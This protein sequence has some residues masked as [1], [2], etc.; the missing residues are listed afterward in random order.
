[1]PCLR[2]WRQTSWRRTIR[3]VEGPEILSRHRASIEA[4]IRGALPTGDAPLD[5]MIRYQMGW[6]RDGLMS[7]G[8]WL[9]PALCLTACEALG[10]DVHRCLPVAASI[11][12]V[13]NFSLIHDD[14]EDGDEVRHHRPALWS[15]YGRGPAIAAGT[16]LWTLAY[17]TLSQAGERGLAPDRVLAARRLLND[18]LLYT[19]PSPRD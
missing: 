12:M 18:C 9:R 3:L 2:D 15:V 7:L 13:H 16:A 14:I 19:S 4:E 11:E 1:M 17:Q 5:E 6:T 8:K 10:G